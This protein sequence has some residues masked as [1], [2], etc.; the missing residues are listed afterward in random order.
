MGDS[1]GGCLALSFAQYIKK[2]KL[3]KPQEIIAISP[4]P[5]FDYDKEEMISYSKLD[6]VLSDGL[7]LGAYN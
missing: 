7:L 1:S 3:V 6:P 4:C 5:R 2:N